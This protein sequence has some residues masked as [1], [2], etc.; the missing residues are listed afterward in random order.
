MRSRAIPGFP[1]TFHSLGGSGHPISAI[2]LIVIRFH[3]AQGEV[4]RVA[5][6]NK[7]H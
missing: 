4:V 3:Q 6:E 7:V 2:L 1:G 5:H